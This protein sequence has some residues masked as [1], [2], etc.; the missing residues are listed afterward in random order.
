MKP[1]FPAGDTRWADIHQVFS[2]ERLK[3]MM[4]AVGIE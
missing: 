4:E 2:N 3:A 1:H